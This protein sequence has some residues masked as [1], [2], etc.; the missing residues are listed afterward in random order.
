MI[1]HRY[2]YESLFRKYVF[3]LGEPDEDGW[4]TGS[5]PFCR[6]P[7]T[8]RVNLKSG[9]WV[10]LPTPP[11]QPHAPSSDGDGAGLEHIGPT[12]PVRMMRESAQ[13]TNRI[14]RE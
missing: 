14:T 12:V 6:E 1:Q 9:R 13:S 10:C 5:C 4:A 2:P 3:D 7:G 11:K 8:F